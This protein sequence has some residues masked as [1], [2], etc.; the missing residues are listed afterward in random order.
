MARKSV[1]AGGSSFKNFRVFIEELGSSWK[2]H[3][4]VI[5]YPVQGHVMPLMKLAYKLADHG[6]KVTF[7]NS[8]SM[9]GKIMAAVPEKLKEKIPI[10]LVSISDGSESNREPKNQLEILKSISSFMPVNLQKLIEDINGLNN[11]E[12]ISC[13]IADVSAGWA[14]E[15]AKKMG[16]KCAAVS[17]YGLGNLVSQLQAPK[18]IEAGVIDADGILTKDELTCLSKAVPGWNMK[19]LSWSFPGVPEVQKLIF[20]HFIR[21]L[22]EHI[23]ISDWLL[24]NSFYELEPLACDFIPDALPIGPLFASNHL[25]PFPGN[26]WPEGSICLSWLDEQPAGSVIYAAFGSSAVCNQ[27]QFNE[28]AHG[29]E[30]LGKPF[31][32]VVRS[33]FTSGL[34]AE[35]PDG[36][37][38]RV[39]NYG[40]ILE[41]APQEKVLA[42]P[43]VACFLSHCGWNSTMEGV[44]MGVPFLCWPFYVD[45]FSNSTYICETWKVGLKLIPDENGIVTRHEIKGKVEKLLSDTDIKANSLKLKEMAGNSISEGGSSSKNFLSFIEQIK[46]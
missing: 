3:V 28:L 1:A 21:N 5:P 33:N 29:L 24:A 22:V 11:D 32:W 41:W 13:I 37:L 34:L 44:C 35:F 46:Q 20:A 6:I 18:L 9:H 16:I 39:A 31:L 42:H 36:Y 23:K 25:G 27:Q 40:K 30:I 19:E 4:M 17:P 12:Q 2:P 10:I 14:L 15:V 38:E 7:V 26:F 45:Q 8:D 43:S